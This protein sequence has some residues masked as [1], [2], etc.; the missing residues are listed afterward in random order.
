MKKQ[1]PKQKRES[2]AV[3]NYAKRFPLTFEVRKAIE[4][5]A[6]TLPPI[7]MANKIGKMLLQRDVKFDK[8]SDFEK[9]GKALSYKK[10]FTVGAKQVLINH[11]VELQTVYQK[12]G[13]RGV[14]SYLMFVE[15]YKE[16][17]KAIEPK[18]ENEEA[19]IQ[20]DL[21]KAE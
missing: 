18:S 3:K 20:G 6:A 21:P 7:P 1:K 11:I 2:K 12:F 15:D 8:Y 9:I 4:Q 14:E 17:I 5:I 16:R 10:N 19:N 13:N